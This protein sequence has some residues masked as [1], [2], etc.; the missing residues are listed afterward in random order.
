[1]RTALESWHDQVPGPLHRDLVRLS[2]RLR[3]GGDAATAIEGLQPVYGSDAFALASL[4][5]VLSRLGGNAPASIDGLASAIDERAAATRSARAAASGARISGRLIAALPLAFLPLAPL[6]RASLLDAINLL[7]LVLGGSLAVAGMTWIDRLVPRPPDED[8][9]AASLADLVAAVVDGGI[10]LHAA[11]DAI[12]TS[13][14]T[15]IASDMQ[16]ARRRVRLGLT[17]T[18]ALARSADA[19][20]QQLGTTL[21]RTQ[22]LGLPVADALRAWARARRKTLARDFEVATRRSGVLMMIPL[23]ICVLPS[24]ILLAVV[25]FLRGLALA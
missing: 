11:L 21:R 23:A 16:R 2:R 18:E 10:G 24:F 14:H 22:A 3:L 5:R 19:S 6:S 12:A 20:L 17:W 13:V 7:L 1:L 4:V 8:D 9:G 25:P 15:D